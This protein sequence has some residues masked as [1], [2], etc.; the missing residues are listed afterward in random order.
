MAITLDSVM[1]ALRT[2]KDPEK[3]RDVLSMGMVHDLKIEGERVS[4]R[5]TIKTPVRHVRESLETQVRNALVSKAGAKDVMVTIDSEA[6]RAR[7]SADR[8]GIPG[9][10]HIVAVSSGKGGVGKS[11]VAANLAIALKQQG[12]KVGLLD[13]DVYGPNIPTMMGVN[14]P[15]QAR[16][17]EKRGELILPPEAHGIKVMS[18]GL[19]TRGDQPLVWRGP[20]LHGVVNQFL[21]N[22]EW[23]EL[24]FLVIDM[25]PGTGD[26][27]LSLSQLVPVSGAV[28]VTTPQEV[29]AQDVR[30]ALLMFEKVGVPILGI[31]E[32]MSFFVCDSCDKRHEIF[33]KGGGQRLAEKYQTRLLAQLPLAAEV[34]EAGDG[35]SPI[36]VRFPESTQAKAFQNLA[37]AVSHAIENASLR[38][39]TE[40]GAPVVNIGE[41]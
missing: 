36:T 10:R 4:L 22:V 27:Q 2:V 34:R 35:G 40:S 19:L 29:S 18:M 39:G 24:D 32:N 13:A 33:G 6:A 26:V 20:M 14:E 21:N 5:L 8:H 11:T 31:V 16:M 38:S 37:R 3:G 25:P 9:I 28:L 17:D 30:K 41:F 1:S 15:P 23:G 7:V 12:A